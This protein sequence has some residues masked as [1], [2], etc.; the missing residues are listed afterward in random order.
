[1]NGGWI[2]VLKLYTKF[3]IV[4]AE[5][6]LLPLQ[7]VFAGFTSNRALPYPNA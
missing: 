3:W 2:I 1:M 7:G 6:W 4:I 5:F